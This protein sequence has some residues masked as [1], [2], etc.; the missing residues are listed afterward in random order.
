MRFHSGL[1][2][3]RAFTRKSNATPRSVRPISMKATGKYSAPR[4]TPCA[5]GNTVSRMPTPSTSQVSLA[6]QKGP[7]L[8]IMVSLSSSPARRISTPTPR[9]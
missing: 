9:S 4:M 5:S 2:L 8:A 7:M 6:S 3:A 1:W